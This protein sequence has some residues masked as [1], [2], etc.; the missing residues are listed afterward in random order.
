MTFFS[1]ATKMTILYCLLA[2]AATQDRSLHQLGVHNAFFHG[3]L[4]EEIY[5]SPP[6][7]FRQ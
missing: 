4:H 6:L 7:G 3:D 2:L 1:P 5:M